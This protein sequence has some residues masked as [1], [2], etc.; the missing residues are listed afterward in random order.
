MG[1]PKKVQIKYHGT[2]IQVGIFDN[3]AS[4]PSST[5]KIDRTAAHL[6]KKHDV[7]VKKVYGYGGPKYEQKSQS[8]EFNQ[9]NSPNNVLDNGTMKVSHDPDN[10]RWHFEWHAH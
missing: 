3:A 1:D 10:N 4:T 6:E 9:L 5:R 2:L 8:D 7:P